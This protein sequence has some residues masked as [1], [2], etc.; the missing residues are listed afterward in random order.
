M[1]SWMGMNLEAKQLVFI[2]LPC[3]AWL[4]LEHSSRKPPGL[5]TQRLKT[6]NATKRGKPDLKAYI[7]CNTHYSPNYWC[8]G[9][10]KTVNSLDTVVISRRS[11]PFSLK[12]TWFSE[13]RC[14]ALPSG[15]EWKTL[16]ASQL[17]A[18]GNDL[19]H[20]QDGCLNLPVYDIMPKSIRQNFRKAVSSSGEIFLPLY[21]EHRRR[22]AFLIG[23]L[24]Y[25]N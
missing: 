9:G 8:R 18:T 20:F 21:P 12:K 2:V 19:S 5:I 15:Y 1:T 13:R 4:E 6:R 14:Q 23:I 25:N 22:L 17:F 3:E 10:L 16:Y 24:V 11:W 7:L